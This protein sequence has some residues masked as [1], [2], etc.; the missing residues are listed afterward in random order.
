[1]SG[2]FKVGERLV[3]GVGYNDGTYPSVNTKEHALWRSMLARCYTERNLILKPAY[4]GCSVSENFKHYTY[5]YEWCNNQKGFKI[6]D[7][8]KRMF[9]LDKDLLSKG[10]K[11]Y[12]EDAC[13]FIPMEINNIIVKSDSLRG[14]YPI[15]VMYDKERDKF[16]S[17][18]WVDNKPKFLG[19]FDNI[20]DAFNKYKVSKES[21]IKTVAEKWKYLIDYRAYEALISYQVEITD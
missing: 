19:R 13:I 14:D 16:Q 9:A 10:N 20:E 6:L 11:V 8:H 2:R 18:M 7:E 4:R 17:R 21:H 5:F 3:A 15:G 1:M 12:S